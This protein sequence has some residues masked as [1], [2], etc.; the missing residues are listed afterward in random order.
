M[1]KSELFNQ[2]SYFFDYHISINKFKFV[3]QMKIVMNKRNHVHAKLDMC[4]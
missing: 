4:Y 3:N 1:L 2:Q